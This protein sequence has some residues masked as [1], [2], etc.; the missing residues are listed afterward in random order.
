MPPC[1]MPHTRYP[2]PNYPAPTTLQPPQLELALELVFC[3]FIVMK[4]A[5]Y[6]CLY[7]SWQ[8]S[9]HVQWALLMAR[10]ATATDG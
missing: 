3:L 10:K 9:H 7:E 8:F 6:V 5:F 4:K 2:I 1:L